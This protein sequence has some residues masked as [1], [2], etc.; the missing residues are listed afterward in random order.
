MMKAIPEMV[1]YALNLVSTFLIYT[2]RQTRLNDYI[3]IDTHGSR[4]IYRQTDTALGLY[5]DRQTRL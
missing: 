2:D 4:I 1:L 3:Q 5:T